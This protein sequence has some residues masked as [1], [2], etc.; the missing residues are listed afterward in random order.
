M[1]LLDPA[2]YWHV[3]EQERAADY[4]AHHHAAS[5]YRT[6][7]RAVD[8]AAPPAVV[9]R[10]LSQ[11]S[12]APYSYD[13]LDNGGR[14]SPRTLTPEADRVAVGQHLMSLFR[15]VE[16][17]P[18]R[19]LTMVSLPRASTIFGELALTYQATDRNRIATDRL[20]RR[21]HPHLARPHAHRPADG[22]RPDHDASAVAQLQG[23][24]RRSVRAS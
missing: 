15:V 4:P 7:L 9:Y 2:R 8:V 19:H 23:A 12:V 11:L 1:A 24:G 21:D 18:D 22:R 14:R 17:E 6:L 3:I 13:W 16:F 20:H 10:W 5:P